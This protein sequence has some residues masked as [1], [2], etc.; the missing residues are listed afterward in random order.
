MF[1]TY[2][3]GCWWLPALL[4]LLDFDAVKLGKPAQV[5]SLYRTPSVAKSLAKRLEG[6]ESSSA[7]DGVMPEEEPAPGGAVDSPSRVLSPKE[8][9]EEEEV[10]L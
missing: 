1:V 7:S 2:F 5:E 9:A 10:D 4:T 6:A 3:L 8:D